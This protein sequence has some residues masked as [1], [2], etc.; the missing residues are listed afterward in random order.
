MLSV[1]QKQKQ[2]TLICANK[3]TI[4]YPSMIFLFSISLKHVR[5][6]DKGQYIWW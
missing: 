5:I 4:F 3:E 2:I 6:R 1:K